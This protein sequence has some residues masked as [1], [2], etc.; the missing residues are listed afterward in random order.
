[1]SVTLRAI[2]EGDLESIMRWR[3]AAE[4][5]RYMNTDPQLT[6]EG[7][8]KWLQ[9]IRENADVRYWLIEVNGAPA[10]VIN[11][12]G[13]T[14]PDGI[15]GWAYYVGEQKLRS[16]QTALALEMSMYD[17]ALVELGKSAVISDVFTLNKG[18]IQLHKI[19]GCEVVEEKKN[20]ILKNDDYYDVTFMRMT[21][22]HWR[23]IRDSKRYEKI[24][25]VR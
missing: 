16:I 1:M 3:M 14:R 7:Q 19:C 10:G 17:Y 24:V 6:L 8:K 11:L 12:T 25:F 4:I 18:V 21:A 22:E 5:T 23:E 15:L 2:E 9:G 20:H 13:L